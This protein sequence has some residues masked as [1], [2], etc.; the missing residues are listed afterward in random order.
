VK[1]KKKMAPDKKSE[2]DLWSKKAIHSKR[3]R[4]ILA[5]IKNVLAFE[6]INN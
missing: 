3:C 4:K 1:V 6:Q 2:K 5:T